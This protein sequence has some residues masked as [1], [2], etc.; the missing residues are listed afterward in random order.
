MQVS[1]I[2]DRDGLLSVAGEWTSLLKKCSSDAISLTP[3]WIAAWWDN[4]G[5]DNRMHVIAVRHGGRLVGVAPMME[6]VARYRRIQIRKITIMANGHSP[7]SGFIADR[8][9]HAEVNGAILSHLEAL[10]GV[11]IIE[12]P[13]LDDNGGT[14]APVLDFIAKKGLRYGIKHGLE[15]PYIPIDTDWDTFFKTRHRKF[16]KAIRNKLNRADKSG[17]ISVEKVTVTGAADPA[18]EE[19]IGISGKSW[20]KKAG[21]DLTSDGNARGFYRSLCDAL[22]PRGV[23]SIW[24]LRKD[25]LPVAFEFHL[26]YNG[27]VYPLR[28]DYDESYA[29]LSPGSVLEYRIVKSLFEEAGAREYYSCGH[30]YMYLLNWS[31]LTRKHVTIEIFS[32]NIRPSTLHILEYSIVPCLRRLGVN[33]V[34]SW[35]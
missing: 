34:M 15:S 13:H 10:P 21:T 33:K 5:A 31:E 9:M 11:D 14:C 2:C 18:V 29:S 23:I 6:A 8:D 22:G 25:S 12:F 4:F 1:V 28:A 26:T 19:M 20:K 16:K 35:F 3:E 7:A 32:R 27:V 30:T 24:L 17:G